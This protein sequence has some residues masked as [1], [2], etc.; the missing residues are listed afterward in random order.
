[1]PNL[2]R[3]VPP[4]RVALPVIVAALVIEI[5][6]GLLQPTGGKPTIQGVSGWL[7]VAIQVLAFCLPPVVTILL[8]RASLRITL[9]LNV[10]ARRFALPVL[11]AAPA[12]AALLVYVQA[13]WAKGLGSALPTGGTKAIGEALSAERPLQVLML[14]LVVGLVPAVS[15]E[16]FF[17]GFLMQ[18]LGTR[19]RP[20]IAIALTAGL[21][22]VLHFDLVGMPTYI[23]LGVWFGILALVTD[24]LFWPV[25]AHLL[26]NGLDIIG[27]NV[28]PP[29]VFE[30]QAAWL[31]WASLACVGWAVW[32]VLGATRR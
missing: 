1:M 14:V 6:L 18:V 26:H 20:W 31:P 10:P 19:W 24:S 22:A 17:R 23:A 16:L 5:A 25:T 28:L 4:A 9:R 32:R 11:V 30:V 29:D 3:D 27:R 7:I 21:F 12:L 13:L 2:S 8:Y 15:E